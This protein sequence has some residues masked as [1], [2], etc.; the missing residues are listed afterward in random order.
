MP[1]RNSALDPARSCEELILEVGKLLA[2]LV[3]SEISPKTDQLIMNSPQMV[4]NKEH[5][6]IRK[7]KDFNISLMC[8]VCALKLTALSDMSPQQRQIVK[9]ILK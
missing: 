4:N 7:P 8:L 9:G 1:Q 2:H 6:Y 5:K 3:F